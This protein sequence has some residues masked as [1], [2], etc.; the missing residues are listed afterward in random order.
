MIPM[1]KVLLSNP[2]SS[3]IFYKLGKKRLCLH[4]A[5]FRIPPG[6][7]VMIF[8]YLSPKNLAK[9]LAFFVQTTPSF[10]VKNVIVTLFFEKKTPIVSPKT[11]T[12]RRKL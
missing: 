12:N 1:K 3:A 8:K 2:I 7:D 9:I 6:T 11:G 5:N 4:L 10:F